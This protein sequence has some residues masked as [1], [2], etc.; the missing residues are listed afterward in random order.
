[1]R[2]GWAIRPCIDML[3]PI[4][5]IISVLCQICNALDVLF[6]ACFLGLFADEVLCQV[7]ILLYLPVNQYACLLTWYSN[8]PKGAP[9]ALVLPRNAIRLPG[10]PHTADL[11][12][13]LDRLPVDEIVR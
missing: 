7:L 12:L 13:L 6:A 9:C 1:V 8:V 4:A 11:M 3:A 5:I 2:E 10:R